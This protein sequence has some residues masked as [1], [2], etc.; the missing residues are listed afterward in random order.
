[1][2]PPLARTTASL[3]AYETFELIKNFYLEGDPTWRRY[4]QLECAA[5]SLVAPTTAALV[6]TFLGERRRLM[7]LVVLG[8]SYFSIISLLCLASTVVPG[9]DWFPAREP[10][11]IAM[12]AGLVPEFSYLGY[13]L[14]RHARRESARE[15]ARTQILALALVLGAGGAST[16]LLAIAASDEASEMPRLAVFGLVGAALLLAS[17][18]FASSC[19]RA[20]AAWC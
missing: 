5:A 10:W 9:L 12:L 15:R 1:M 3:F 4:E 20:C 11:A 17:L 7:W 6:L 16:D 14:V 8:A 19:S 2:A 18:A 13:L